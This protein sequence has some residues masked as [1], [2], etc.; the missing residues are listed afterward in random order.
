MNRGQV[1]NCADHVGDIN[2]MMELG[3]NMPELGG[4][5]M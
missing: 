4:G 3:N 2:N 5:V 1:A